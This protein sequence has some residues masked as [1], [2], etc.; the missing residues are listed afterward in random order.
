MLVLKSRNGELFMTEADLIAVRVVLPAGPFVEYKGERYFRLA[1]LPTKTITL[2]EAKQTIAIEFKAEALKSSIS[3]GQP[4]PAPVPVL[5]APGMFL[6]YDIHAA[7]AQ[8]ES[9][10]SANTEFGHFS[11]LGNL[12]SAFSLHPRDGRHALVRLDTTFTVDRPEKTASLRLG[13][14]ISR[15]A[16]GW[17]SALRFAGIQYATN[18]RVNPGLITLPIQVFSAQAAL[19]S[20]VDVFVNNVLISRREVAPGPFSLDDLPALSGSG[21]VSM[22]VRDLSGREQVINQPFYS[23]SSLLRKGIVD[24][25]FE[26]GALRRNYGQRNN[27]YGPGFGSGTLRLGL[28][29]AITAETHLQAQAGGDRVAGVNLL[30]TLASLAS[31]NASLA[32]SDSGAGRGRLWALGVERQSNAFSV[33]V[34]TQLADPSFRRPGNGSVANPIHRQTSA[35]LGVN[36][37]GAGTLNA[38]YVRQTP[39]GLA[40]V[41]LASVNYGISL[42]RFGSLTV[43]GFKSLEGPPS[44]SLVFNWSMPLG[45]K[46]YVSASHTAQDGAE[47]VTRL[48]F[49]RPLDPASGVGYRLQT[50]KNAQ[51]R[52]TL[53]LQNRVGDYSLEAAS[54]KGETGV[55]AK[56]SGGVAML[57]GA[58]FATRRISDSFGV[59][60][61]PDLPNVR[62]YVDNRLTART[63]ADGYALLP[64][65]RAY[66]NNSVRV[67]QTDLDMDVKVGT[68]TMKAVPY[69]R[70]GI[71]LKFPISRAYGATMTLRGAQGEP[72]IAGSMVRVN[73]S[74]EEFPVGNDGEVYLTGLVA[75][76]SLKVTWPAG[77]CS[78]TVPFKTTSDPLPNLGEFICLAE[79]P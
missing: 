35:N 57:G 72:V 11:K 60:Q 14:A 6:N 41:A 77:A 40:R 37:R 10:F 5:S 55:R 61:L 30:G 42:G 43:S 3:T 36:L 76:N 22:V 49:Q 9:T 51:H 66:E 32:I 31:V 27:D 44:R 16:S 46:Y 33:G 70:S 54:F 62:I 53:L 38:F 68:L 15:P 64:H 50:G 18:F 12:V 79:K 28:T 17:G 39:L 1:S 20:T 74:E 71:L 59:V 52:A 75:Q 34:R 23:S 8:S 73:G 63:N 67:E 24:F 4:A 69:A 26:A 78:V 29:D 2:D 45:R 25:S 19:P 21:D 48:R 56:M 58:T 47:N 13:D 7:R 65:L